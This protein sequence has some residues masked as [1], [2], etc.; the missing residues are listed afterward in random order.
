MISGKIGETGIKV[1]IPPPYPEG[2]FNTNKEDRRMATDYVKKMK[3][4]YGKKTS[5]N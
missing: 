4:S 5:K 3:K 2:G 1:Q